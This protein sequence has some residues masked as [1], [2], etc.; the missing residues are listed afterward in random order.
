MSNFRKNRGKT[1]TSPVQ[2]PRSG[3]SR[4]DLKAPQPEPHE[5]DTTMSKAFD[6]SNASDR[7]VGA[8]FGVGTMN[9]GGA[10]IGS[11][12]D[13]DVTRPGL[14]PPNEVRIQHAAESGPALSGSATGAVQAAFGT[15]IESALQEEISRR[16]VADM[17]HALLFGTTPTTAPIP[18][19]QR[20]NLIQGQ[21]WPAFVRRLDIRTFRTPV[22]ERDAFTRFRPET[23]AD[24][25]SSAY[26]AYREDMLI[27]LQIDA[28]GDMRVAPA[29]ASLMALHNRVVAEG[30]DEIVATIERATMMTSWVASFIFN[31]DGIPALCGI[32]DMGGSLNY[33]ICGAS[34]RNQHMYRPYPTMQ[35]QGGR[36]GVQAAIRDFL[37]N[38]HREANP[39]LTHFLRE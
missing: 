7:T 13:M 18:T 12:V 11:V 10:P 14:M 29:L 9:F 36:G 31:P 27:D 6:L 22:A 24:R 23:D 3:A 30:L 28:H 16:A 33:V 8:T 34:F 2:V 37:T 19:R 32:L 17:E 39:G 35:Y 21:D 15:A 5:F 38:A 20:I 26:T 4:R 25:P 1:P